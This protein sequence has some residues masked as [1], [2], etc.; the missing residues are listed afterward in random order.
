MALSDHTW[1]RI[2]PV[3]GEP[4]WFMPM[5]GNENKIMPQT[6][7]SRYFFVGLTRKGNYVVES[8][9]LW[10]EL[11]HLFSASQYYPVCYVETGE[12]RE[13]DHNDT[14]VVS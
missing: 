14:K 7:H 6:I 3:V 12:I 9:D 8:S 4:V 11:P 2:E 1:Q 5:D 10:G 13:R